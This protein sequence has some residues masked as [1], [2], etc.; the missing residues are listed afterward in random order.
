[1]Y[2]DKKLAARFKDVEATQIVPS[3]QPGIYVEGRD[4]TKWMGIKVESSM[5]VKR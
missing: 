5:V 2:G 4:S 1:M 3:L